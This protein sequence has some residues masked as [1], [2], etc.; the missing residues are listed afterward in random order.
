MG[1][2]LLVASC[3]K[4][5]MWIWQQRLVLPYLSYGKGLS[6]VAWI[7]LEIHTRGRAHSFVEGTYIFGGKEIL[8]HMGHLGYKSF[9]AYLTVPWVAICSWQHRSPPELNLSFSMDAIQKNSIT[10]QDNSHQ[11]ICASYGSML[12]EQLRRMWFKNTS[13]RWSV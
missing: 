2:P 9:W 8:D 5:H 13:S 6:T 1:I 11:M 12:H 4:A 7:V 10:A 3:V